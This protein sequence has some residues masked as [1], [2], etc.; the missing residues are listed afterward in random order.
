MSLF[1]FRINFRANRIDK[2]ASYGDFVAM[3]G[4][5]KILT[6]QEISDIFKI[7]KN[8]RDRTLFALGIYTGMRV[9][10]IIGLKWE[11]LYTT[12]GGVRNVLKVISAWDV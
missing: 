5:A 9:G 1:V 7:L 6:S 3:P 2:V 4:R 12:S 10:E 8:P 11:Q